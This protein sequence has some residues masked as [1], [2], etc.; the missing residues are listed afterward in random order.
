MIE[1]AP[2]CERVRFQGDRVSSI[3]TRKY[4]SNRSGRVLV[5][6]DDADFAESLVDLL[7]HAGHDCAAAAGPHEATDLARSFRPQVALLD[8][9]LGNSNGVDLVPRLKERHEETVCIMMTAFSEVESAARAVRLGADDYLQK[10][11]APEMLLER[12]QVALDQYEL[13][14]ERRIA[15]ETL[16]ARERYL[17]AV[18]DNIV[19]GVITFDLEGRI[20]SVN[21]M[22]RRILNL[23]LEGPVRAKVQDLLAGVDAAP[24][25][26]RTEDGS[27]FEPREL[28]MVCPLGSRYVLSLS[29]SEVEGHSPPT[30]IAVVQ[31]ITQ[32]KEM[33]RDLR[34]AKS[35]AESASRAKSEF[36]AHMSH[37]LRTPLNAILGFSQLMDQEIKGPLGAP[38]YRSYVR[39]IY[40]SGNHLLSL[41]N[42]ILDVSKL[43]AGRYELKEEPVDVAEVIE[44]ALMLVRARS[45]E[46]RVNL[47]AELSAGESMLRADRRMVLQ[48]LA[49]LLSNAVKFASP[50]ARVLVQTSIDA[51]GSYLIEVSDTGPGMSQGEI[52]VALTPFGRAS[53]LNSRPKEGTGLGLPLAQSFARLHGGDL[54]IKSE[55][56]RGTTV[57]VRF[58]RARVTLCP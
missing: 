30:L 51:S 46:A 28:E 11:V 34:A 5:V 20:E 16:R 15:T 37:E 38:E 3:S 42:D 18:L 41:I 52:I 19:D 45:E 33:E 56:G 7:S 57:S 39:D 53:S 43:E 10:P 55:V 31:D 44:R 23:P 36:L 8:V 1:P 54:S 47:R 29:V 49:N 27:L 35:I 48:I 50:G 4:Q 26:W 9:R 40:D 58:P 17:R 14:L 25:E 12:I 32:R 22:A 13:S 24:F 2:I 6:D 21:P